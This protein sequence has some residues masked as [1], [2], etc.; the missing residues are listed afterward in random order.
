MFSKMKDHMEAWAKAMALGT[1]HEWHKAVVH[2]MSFAEGRQAEQD[3]VNLLVSKGYVVLKDQVE[4]KAT[5]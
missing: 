4:V 1:E 5:T 3:A 2:F